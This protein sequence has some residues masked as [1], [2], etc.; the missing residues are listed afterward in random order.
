[1]SDWADACDPVP[2]RRELT[3]AE[4]RRLQALLELRRRKGFRAMGDDVGAAYRVLSDF[5]E[6]ES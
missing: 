1:M 6:V 2:A 5:D 3:P 4:R